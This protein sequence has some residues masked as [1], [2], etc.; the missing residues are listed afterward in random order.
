MGS[1]RLPGST[2]RRLAGPQP[3]PGAL[4]TLCRA[5]RAGTGVG[6]HREGQWV[7]GTL[8]SHQDLPAVAG[9]KEPRKGAGAKEGR[10]CISAAASICFGAGSGE[11]SQSGWCSQRISSQALG[12]AGTA[13]PHTWVFAA[14]WTWSRALQH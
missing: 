4:A 13:V 1:E 8:S 5:G 14:A 6:A 12:C 10:S 2:L 7:Q 11:G 9:A 3:G